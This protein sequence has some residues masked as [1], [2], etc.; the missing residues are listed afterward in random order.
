MSEKKTTNS[1]GVLLSIQNLVKEYSVAAGRKRALDGV[2]LDIYQGE[3]FGLL[4]A[5]GAGKTTL[6]SLLATFNPP[7]SGSIVFEG[8]SIFDDIY[9]YRMQLGFCPQRPNLDSQLTVKENLEFAARYYLQ[10]EKEA[11]K[12]IAELMDRFSL[13][14]YAHSFVENLSGGYRQRLS[15]AR[16]LVHNPRIVILDEPTVAL[17]PH[18]RRAIWESIKTLKSDG[19]TVILTTHYLDEAEELSDRVCILE[20]GTVLQLGTP[21]ELMKQHGENSLEDVFIRL[22]NDEE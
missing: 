5:N 15:I 20:K 4:G 14:K 21:A 1:S 6:S 9:A 2:S 11:K 3:I 19:V 17:D 8:K 13:D 10:P 22:L 12:R 16:A 18:V 7:T